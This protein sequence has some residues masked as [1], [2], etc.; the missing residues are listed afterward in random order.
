[1]L[2]IFLRI[3]RSYLSQAAGT[4]LVRDWTPRRFSENMMKVSKYVNQKETYDSYCQGGNSF[5]SP[6]QEFFGVSEW[7]A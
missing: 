7:Q 1:M 4:G 3:P 2:F 6:F 5:L